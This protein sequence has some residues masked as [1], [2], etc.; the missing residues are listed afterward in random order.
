MH[1]EGAVADHRDAGP[2]GRGELGAEHAGDAKAHRAEAHGADQ[3]IRPARLAELQQPVVVHADVA[4][5]DRVLGQRAVDLV[6]GALRVDRRGVVAE[7][8]RDERVPFSGASRRSLRAS[9]AARRLARGA[10]RASISAST[11]RR[12]VRTSAISPS[13]TG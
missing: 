11:W 2:V 1:E 5:E 7:A 4:D 6:R 10:L 13:A 3:R 8:G 12:N 9:P